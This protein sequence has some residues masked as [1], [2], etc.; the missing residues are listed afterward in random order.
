MND[1]TPFDAILILSFGGPEGPDDVVPFLENVTRGRGIPRERL[2]VVGQHYFAFGGVSPINEEC[3]K[4]IAELELQLAAKG[5]H[6]PVY[7]GNRNW[8]PFLEETLARM[9]EDGIR[10]AVAVATS[11]FSSYS[12]C[13]QYQEDIDK[14]VAAVGAKA[15]RIEKLPP[16]WNHPGFL[17]TMAANTRSALARL[18]S[19]DTASAQP[20][21][22]LVFTAHSIPLAMAS[23]CD[24]EAE[25]LEAAALVAERSAPGLAWDLV[26]Q[27]RSGPPSQ[28]WLEPDVCVH[29][30]ALAARG[31]T[32][33][34]L[35]P[36]GFVA[37]HM[38]VRY[39]LDTEARAVADE[40]GLEMTRAAAVGAAPS[41]VA[42][43]RELVQ[44]HIDGTSP[45]CLGSRGARPFPCRPDCCVYTP[46][47]PGA[48]P[49]GRPAPGS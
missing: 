29:L 5:P 23:G 45:A 40:L 6:L 12:A 15:P 48:A 17:E 13:R 25:L 32:R 24:Y 41:F 46:Q 22:R 44:A 42:G 31:T 33:V 39:D 7:W 20:P 9:S 14:A 27:S 47:R 19:A 28:P 11:A 21:T 49:P 18:G 38:E 26:Y 30:R 35:V 36:L 2:A 37:D 43:L 34:V 16:Y 4:L 8:H 10:R 3:R 1:S